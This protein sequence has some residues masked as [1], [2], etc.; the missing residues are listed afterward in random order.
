M[1]TYKNFDEKNYLDANPDVKKAI[2]RGDFVDG[3]EHYKKFGIKEMRPLK[4]ETSR[5]GKVFCKLNKYGRGLEIGPSHRPIAPKKDGFNVHILD[6]LSAQD[7]KEK[8]KDHGVNLDNIEDVD[9]IWHGEPFTELIGERDYYDWII[10]SH[11]IEH[12]PDMISFL[13]QCAEILKKDGKLSLVIPDKRYCF[14]YFSPL[15]STGDFLDAYS[16]K[17]TRPTSGQI[18]DH[19]VNASKRFNNIAWADDDLGGADELSSNFSEAESAYIRSM[20]SNE[21]ID[22]H[23]SRFTPLSFQLIV[24]D[25]F[26]LRLIAFDVIQFYET[27]GCEFYITLAKTDFNSQGANN[28]DRLSEL[29]KIRAE[30]N[31]KKNYMRVN[32]KLK[33]VFMKVLNQLKCFQKIYINGGVK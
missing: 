29:K 1:I 32:E 17:R 28:K 26:R 22:I 21:Y 15:S 19:I 2:E 9:Y 13:N 18:F 23:C 24:S 4:N 31:D 16:E 30:I 8:Y 20:N 12:V 14:D 27:E 6:H 5:F 33:R 3:L 10:A 7:L 25:L 11:V